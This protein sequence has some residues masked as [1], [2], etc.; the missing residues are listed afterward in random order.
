MNVSSKRNE[1]RINPEIGLD[2][3]LSVQ[4]LGERMEEGVVVAAAPIVLFKQQA[5]G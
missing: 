3:D 1:T 5:G 2:K 4:L